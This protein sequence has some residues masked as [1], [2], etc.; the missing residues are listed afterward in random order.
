MITDQEIKLRKSGTIKIE[1]YQIF[2]KIRSG[3]GGGLLTAVDLNLEP[4]LIESANEESEILTVQCK[5]DLSNI[6][7]I[8]GYGPQEDD[9]VIK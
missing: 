3:F 8:N 9:P 6:R 2:E 5:I 4:V 7:I 1:N